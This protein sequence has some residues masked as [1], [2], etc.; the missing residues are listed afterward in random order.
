MIRR[1]HQGM[2]YPPLNNADHAEKNQN[3]KMDIL[4]GVNNQYS[5]NTK[6][7][8]FEKYDRI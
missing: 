8:E 6:E 4:D 2:V 5:V 3:I 1:F 7:R